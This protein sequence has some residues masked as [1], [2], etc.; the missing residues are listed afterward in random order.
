MEKGKSGCAFEV[1]Y[2]L[3]YTDMAAKERG[4]HEA[5]DGG[6]THRDE[7]RDAAFFPQ[8]KKK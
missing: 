7:W 8:N 6:Q 5:R 4:K 3:V 1:H 2:G